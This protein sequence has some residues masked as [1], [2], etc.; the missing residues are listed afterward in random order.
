MG[1]AGAGETDDPTDIT[2]PDVVFFSMLS[3]LH[4]L[5][6]LLDNSKYILNA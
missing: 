4:K 5:N 3:L 2:A 6:V 1:Q